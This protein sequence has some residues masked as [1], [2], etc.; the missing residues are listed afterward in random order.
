M[1]ARVK[2]EHINRN[3]KRIWGSFELSD[4]STTEFDIDR[5]NSWNQWGNTTDNLYLT[6]PRL[7]ELQA[8]LF[9]F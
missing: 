4:G 2:T 3:S 8:E 9:D 7:E 5:E 1:T 6:V